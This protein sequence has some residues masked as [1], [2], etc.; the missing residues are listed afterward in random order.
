[1]FVD[2]GLVVRLSEREKQN[3]ADLFLAVAVS[4]NDEFVSKTRNCVSMT[5]DFVQN[6]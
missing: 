4:T 2:A 1:M 5:R 3:F 6:K